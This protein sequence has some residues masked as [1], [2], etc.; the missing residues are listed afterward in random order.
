MA[1]IDALSVNDLE[2]LLKERKN[3][4]TELQKK[5]VTLKK[6]LEGVNKEISTLKGKKAARST[7]KRV[8]K[9]R[10]KNAQSLRAMIADLLSGNKKGLTVDEIH[11]AVLAG[12]YKSNS[13]NFKNVVYQT[14]YHRDDFASDGDSGKWKLK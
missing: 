3:R 11:E 5:Q 6:E 12:G 2:S 1:R 13:K 9:R 10:P 8:K 7:S 14:L 4:L